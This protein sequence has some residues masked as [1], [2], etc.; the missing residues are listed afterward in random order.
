MAVGAGVAIG[1][2]LVFI[3]LTPKDSGPAPFLVTFIVT[4]LVTSV[5]ILF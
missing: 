3:D 4:G 2:Y 5:A 1:G